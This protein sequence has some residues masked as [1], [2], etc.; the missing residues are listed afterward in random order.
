MQEHGR[1]IEWFGAI[2]VGAGLLDLRCSR[3]LAHEVCETLRYL[4]TN[5]SM[6][7]KSALAGCLESLGQLRR[8]FDDLASQGLH[9]S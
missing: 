1:F 5:P 4:R 7:T 9:H 3:R 6:W 2:V 8:Q